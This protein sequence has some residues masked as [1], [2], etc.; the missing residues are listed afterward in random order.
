MGDKTI[1]D[2]AIN[3]ANAKEASSGS[4]EEASILFVGSKNSGKT[5]IILRFLDRDE[6]PKP[7]TAL[8]YTFGRRAKG[9][10]IAK[11]VGHIWEL[12]GG[13]WLSKLLDVPINEENIKNIS[14]AIV[15]D[16]SL[17]NELWFT[18]ENLIKSAKQRID[19]VIAN[20]KA[21]NP[22]VVNQL[23][24]ASWERI[25]ENNPDKEMISPFP[26]PLIIIGSKYDVFQ[27]FD[28]ERR[29]IICK[30]LRFVAHSYGAT[31]QFFSC[32][33]EALM[34]RARALI[35]H[36][37]FATAASKT[38]QVE[39]TK[40][41]LVPCGL[42]SL[43]QIGTPPVGDDDIGRVTA[44]NPLELWKQAYCGHF[45]QENTNNPAMVEDPAK[46]NQ[47]AEHAIDQLRAQKDEELERY[48]RLSERR[49]K[50]SQQRA[51]AEGFV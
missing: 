12:G 22:D 25:G 21:S 18:L 29:K 19:D 20:L 24:K 48:R 37:L 40:P 17:P 49:A 16:L 31:L 2:L 47:Y 4:N 8:E 34:T 6:A 15:V 3:E 23:I 51:K 9:H 41:L 33:Q 32:K 50:E 39:H 13:T 28:S 46:D 44:R 42:D 45:P 5:S 43:Q 26:I 27:D 14:L 7:T 30:T 36:H 38:L 35:S 1:W 10:N 11:D